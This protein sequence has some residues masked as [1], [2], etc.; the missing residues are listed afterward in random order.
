MLLKK[1]LFAALAC[2]MMASNANAAEKTKKVYVYGTAI[3]FND[4]T[5]YITDIQTLDSAVITKKSKFLYGRDSYSYQ[6]RDYLKANETST[7]TCATTF[8]TK[9]KDIEKKYIATKKRYG[10]GKFILKHITPNQFQFSTIEMDNDEE[11]TLSKQERKALK[12]K[13]KAERKKEKA[14]T[15]EREKSNKPLIKL[16]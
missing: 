9:Q 12:K 1:Y 2:L 15:Q 11:V 14:E 6:F 7:P 8:A 13:E 16:A 4:S 5:V 10:N 3:S